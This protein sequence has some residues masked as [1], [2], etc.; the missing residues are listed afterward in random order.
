M[1]DL[2]SSCGLLIQQVH[3][4]LDPVSVRQ[5]S[6]EMENEKNPFEMEI[7]DSHM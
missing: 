5:W 2:E 4:I 6:H 3:L 1:A 7:R